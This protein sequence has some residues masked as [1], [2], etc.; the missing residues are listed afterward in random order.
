MDI[1]KLKKDGD[2]YRDVE[3]QW[4]FDLYGFMPR[5]LSD[6]IYNNLRKIIETDDKSEWAYE[7]FDRCVLLLIEGK[8]WPDEIQE[9]YEEFISKNKAHHIFN[10][11][12]KKLGKVELRKYRPHKSITRDPWVMFYAACIHLDKRVFIHLKPQSQLYRPNLWALRKA[13]IGEKNYYVF[14][15]AINVALHA[16]PMSKPRKDFVQILEQYRN[17][18]YDRR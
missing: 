15:R 16:M 7:V 18:C 1:S 14:W 10:K 6:L 8:R 5:G 11:W 3:K 12:L 17:W 2:W 4:E 13:L 9:E